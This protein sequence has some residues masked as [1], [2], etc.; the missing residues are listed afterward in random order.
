MTPLEHGVLIGALIVFVGCASIVLA[1]L[2]CLLWRV[3]RLRRS[4]DP[5][6]W[7][8]QQERRRWYS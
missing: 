1:M 4:A 2:L 8:H 5:Q 3:A 6:V 7:L